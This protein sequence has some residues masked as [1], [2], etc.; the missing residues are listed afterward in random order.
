MG[1][2]PGCI[3]LLPETGVML[4]FGSETSI[5]GVGGSDLKLR[6]LV[7]VEK[8][9]LC[10]RRSA[11]SLGGFGNGL[12]YDSD[13]LGI[14]VDFETFEGELS[15]LSRPN[16]DCCGEWMLVVV[17]WSSDRVSPGLNNDDDVLVPVL[18]L[19]SCENK[20]RTEGTFRK[21]LT[22][23]WEA[24]AP[25]CCTASVDELGI[26]PCNKAF[27]ESLTVGVSVYHIERDTSGVG[28]P[29]PHNLDGGWRK[30]DTV[31]TN[32]VS[33]S[34]LPSSPEFENSADE[35]SENWDTTSS[36]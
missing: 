4:S 16:G 25:G 13:P 34:V 9:E 31:V 36:S 19:E 27:N 10:V 11:D 22:G 15:L 14:L 1:G 20:G 7:V 5:K 18:G 2:D 17:G 28:T 32:E 26:V 33:L 29:G 24:E 21:P 6:V 23:V 8:V 3:W 30:A 12:R 35:W